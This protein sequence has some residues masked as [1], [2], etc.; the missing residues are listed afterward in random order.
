MDDDG[1]KIEHIVGF[2]LDLLI[3]GNIILKKVRS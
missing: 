1:S 2:I 3:D